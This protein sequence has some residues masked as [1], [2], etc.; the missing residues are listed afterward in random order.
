VRL[1]P[2]TLSFHR[3]M[4]VDLGGITV[5]LHALRGH[6]EDCIVAF[7]PQWG[8]LLAGDTVE[9]PLPY[10]N[11]ADK[12]TLDDWIDGL[13]GWAEHDRMQT[14]IPAHGEIGGKSVIENN[15]RYL[16]DLRDQKAPH[17]PSQLDAFYT[18]THA[19]NL[20]LAGIG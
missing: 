4:E 8:I 20:K 16:R 11:T 9:T 17:V 5:E 13:A 3:R 19:N 18:E 10:L 15:V 2:P 12:L 1:I 7:I 14:M 6:T